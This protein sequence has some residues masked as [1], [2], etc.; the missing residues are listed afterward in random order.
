MIKRDQ[1]EKVVRNGRG[2]KR[3]KKKMATVGTVFTQEP[4]IRS[5]EE[6]IESLFEPEQKREKR[7]FPVPEN[8][9]V[10]ASLQKSKDD[11]I[12]SIGQE[13][14]R[15]DPRGVKTWVVVA[16]GE[17][18]LRIR[19]EKHLP[20][21][22][23]LILDLFHV[24]EK[25]WKAVYVFHPEGSEAAKEWVRQRALRIL[26]GEVSQVVKGLR[27]SATKRNLRGNKLKAVEDAA[28]YFYARRKYM[29]YDEYLKQGLPIAS[30]AVEGACK[31]L[32]KD[33][34][35]RSGMRWSKE[36]AEAMI[37]LRA[38]YRSGDW[39]EYWRYHIQ[40]DQKRIFPPNRWK[41]VV[42]K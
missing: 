20:N 24:L 16:D 40:Q 2:K 7:D 34:M 31:N 11:V 19:V 42:E 37:Q 8:K 9:R 10:W 14:A 4:R 41:K 26:K 18:A 13:M 21:N 5:P 1:T 29:K 6:V 23:I 22:V 12:V 28:S 35:E 36:T 38:T 25:L 27:Q 33:R 32:I 15:R 39:G 30:G 17:R 3:H